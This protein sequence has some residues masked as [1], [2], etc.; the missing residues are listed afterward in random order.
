M[1]TKQFLSNK[2]KTEQ[3]GQACA[4]REQSKEASAFTEGKKEVDMPIWL[5][6]FFSV[7]L[8]LHIILLSDT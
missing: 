2:T 4:G 8:L 3:V 6:I 5:C 7:K 1:S